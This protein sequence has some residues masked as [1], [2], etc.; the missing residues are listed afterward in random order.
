MKLNKFIAIV[1]CCE[2]NAAEEGAFWHARTNLGGNYLA[3]P[4]NLAAVA[5]NVHAFLARWR[6]YRTRIDWQKLAHIWTPREQS[7]AGQLQCL[8]LEAASGPHAPGC[9]PIVSS[10]VRG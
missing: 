3:Q 5:S 2:L 8:G 10:P 6:S 7:I 1:T 9:G 4:L